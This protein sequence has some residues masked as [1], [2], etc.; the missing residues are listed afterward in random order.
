MVSMYHIWSS[1][2]PMKFPIV[3]ERYK[4]K[5]LLRNFYSFLQGERRWRKL[6]E[7]FSESHLQ[8]DAL[9]SPES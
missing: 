9:T 1:L 4:E 5:R 8:L 7:V 6:E 3:V 2:V